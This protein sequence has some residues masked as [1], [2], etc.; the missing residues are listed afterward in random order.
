MEIEA[1]VAE[2]NAEALCKDRSS[3]VERPINTGKPDNAK[4]VSKVIEQVIIKNE[5]PSA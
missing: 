2:P 5:D 4:Q 3:R 1:I